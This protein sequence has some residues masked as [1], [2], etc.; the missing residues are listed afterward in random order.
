MG[1]TM[2]ANENT[3]MTTNFVDRHRKLSFL[4]PVVVVAG[5]TAAAISGVSQR[6]ALVA[7]DELAQLKDAC[8]VAG[9]KNRLDETPDG[10]PSGLK[11]EVQPL[12]RRD[13]ESIATYCAGQRDLSVIR[14][15]V[16][17]QRSALPQ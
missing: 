8:V 12:T 2:K 1:I 4:L 11:R 3:S 16:A 14:N 9:V 7:P 15:T 13:L 6:S 17:K 10:Y 5:L